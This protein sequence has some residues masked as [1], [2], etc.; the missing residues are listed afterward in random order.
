MIQP[1]TPQINRLGLDLISQ[2]SQKLLP[3]YQHITVAGARKFFFGGPIILKGFHKNLC[4]GILSW[5]LTHGDYEWTNHDY[6]GVNP[7]KII[8]DSRFVGGCPPSSLD[9]VMHLCL[10]D[11]R[12]LF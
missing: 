5:V 10:W 9:F 1:A 3:P 4:I 2:V 7:H 11:E 8:P 12:K 6:N